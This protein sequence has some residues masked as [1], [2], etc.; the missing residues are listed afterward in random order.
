MER[1][2]FFSRALKL[3]GLLGG[4]S[5]FYSMFRFLFPGETT[6][7]FAPS[8]N[9][10]G[11]S[12]GGAPEPGRG[13]G[14]HFSFLEM[15][16]RSLSPGG[17]AT[18]AIGHIPVILVRRQEGIVAFRAACTHLG[19]LVKWEAEG[20]RFVCPCHGGTFDAEGRVVSGP[21]AA[22]LRK[23]LVEIKGDVVRVS[24]DGPENK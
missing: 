23:C 11:G 2:R 10:K 17:S 7:D 18:V 20:K 21:P 24:L 1:R 22:A 3:M 19:C 5:F 12:E 4:G 8:A 16:I 15:K 6:K 13:R 14:P 9:P